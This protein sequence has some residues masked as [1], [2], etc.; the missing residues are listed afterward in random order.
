MLRSTFFEGEGC[1][2]TSTFDNRDGLDSLHLT[3]DHDHTWAHFHTP[4]RISNVM[5]W[6]ATY[7]A[8]SRIQ[9]LKQFRSIGLTTAIKDLIDNG[10]PE[11][12]LTHFLKIFGEKNAQTQRSVEAAMAELGWLDDATAEWIEIRKALVLRAHVQDRCSEHDVKHLVSLAWLDFFST[13]NPSH[14]IE[15]EVR[16]TCQ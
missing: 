4:R 13:L 8:L 11:G 6:I 16:E 5:K 3:G 1:K 10:P 12:F 7:M 15:S 9:S 14:D 2:R